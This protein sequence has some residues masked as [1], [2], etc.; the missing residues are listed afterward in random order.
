VHGGTPSR[1][2]RGG[3]GC[4]HTACG[5]HATLR[6]C[7]H[8]GQRRTAFLRLGLLGSLR[9]HPHPYTHNLSVNLCTQSMYHMGGGGLL[10]PRLHSAGGHRSRC[11]CNAASV[12]LD[13]RRLQGWYWRG[14]VPEAVAAFPAGILAG[15]CMCMCVC[16][17]VCVVWL[18]QKGVSPLALWS[19]A[20]TASSCPL[21]P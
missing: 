6:R 16:V 3:R 15:V 13:V 19:P 9:T 11:A 1:D 7:C 17:R 14:G 10:R 12:K 18:S 20:Q 2:A 8:G 5:R 21:A 4:G